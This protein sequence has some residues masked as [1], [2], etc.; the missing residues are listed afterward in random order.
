MFIGT[1]GVV[2]ASY[3][4]KETEKILEDKFHV[5]SHTSILFFVCVLLV[6]Y[7]YEG[8]KARFEFLLVL[9]SA[10]ATI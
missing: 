1:F 9:I 3:G 5:F 8:F 6:Y 4:N 7:L 2:H 10:K